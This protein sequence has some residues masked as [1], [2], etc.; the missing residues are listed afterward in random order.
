[1]TILV[2]NTGQI[3]FVHTDDLDLGELGPQEIR[4]ASR[5]EPISAADWQADLSPV[6]G[7]NLRGFRRRIDALQAEI[8]WLDEHLHQIR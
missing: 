5:V 3:R 1:M 2:T 8:A 7:P 6:G 4:R